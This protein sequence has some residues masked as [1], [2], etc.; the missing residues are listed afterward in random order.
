MN[1]KTFQIHLRQ[2]FGQLTQHVYLCCIHAETREQA[3]EWVS[4]VFPGASLEASSATIDASQSL[5]KVGDSRPVSVI[6]CDAFSLQK[7]R[8]GHEQWPIG[9]WRRSSGEVAAG[10]YRVFESLQQ[11]R[12]YHQKAYAFDCQCYERSGKETDYAQA[13]ARLAVLNK[14]L[15]WQDAVW[16]EYRRLEAA[17]PRMLPVHQAAA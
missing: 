12:V 7:G 15:S 13:S 17:H 11:E 6:D 4:R 8:R 3:W 2:P 16:A 10:L 14:I 5:R 9:H 1:P